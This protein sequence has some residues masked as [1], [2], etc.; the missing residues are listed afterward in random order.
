MPPFLVMFKLDSSSVTFLFCK[1]ASFKYVGRK[2][3]AV[4]LQ[5]AVMKVGLFA[6]NVTFSY[7]T[8]GNDFKVIK[9]RFSTP[10]TQ[11]YFVGNFHR[12]ICTGLLF[13]LSDLTVFVT[14]M[15]VT[16]IGFGSLISLVN[17]LCLG[18]VFISALISALACVL[19]FVFV[20]GLFLFCFR[21]FKDLTWPVSLL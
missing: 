5:M 2:Q 7:R 10:K 9:G 15:T 17:S 13:F 21:S 14:R 19:G 6:S 11:C 16:E 18:V 3:S 4:N 1:R 8:R 12:K 20:W